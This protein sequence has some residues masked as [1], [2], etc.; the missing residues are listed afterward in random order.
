MYAC[1][2]LCSRNP[3]PKEII[4]LIKTLGAFDPEARNARDCTP[5]MSSILRNSQDAFEALL[6]HYNPRL[7]CVDYRGRS[8]MHLAVFHSVAPEFIEY[9]LTVPGLPVDEPAHDGTTP[10]M[11]ALYHSK[12]LQII[13]LLVESNQVNLQAVVLGR[14]VLDWAID[15]KQLPLIEYVLSLPVDFDKIEG[16]TLS[17]LEYAK[18]I[19]APQDII[20]LL[21]NKSSI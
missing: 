21:V 19:E 7:D 5:L 12:P 16:I 13:K 17:S 4:S 9:L 18:W 1:V 11:R 2:H 15:S 8:L 10:L 14:S 3:C 20:D 6:H